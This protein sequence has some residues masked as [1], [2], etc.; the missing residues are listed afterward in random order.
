[1]A[2]GTILQSMAGTVLAVC[3]TLP[4]TY[5]AAGYAD[6]DLVFTAVGE[7]EDHGGHG[8][9][10]N[11]LQFTAVDDAIVQKF[12]GSKNYGTKQLVLGN[13]PSDSGQD[14]LAAAAE[15]NNRY[16]I[17][18]TYPLRQGE[19]TNEVHYLDALI[20]SFSYQDGPVDS[21]RKINV[22]LEICRAPV[23]VAAT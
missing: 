7:I 3:A 10:A 16:S 13:I 1:M 4:V 22:G 6:T 5:D 9:Q 12:K 14:I 20:T 19:V 21:L 15:S 11:V 23:I 18:I 8:V 17:K 2:E